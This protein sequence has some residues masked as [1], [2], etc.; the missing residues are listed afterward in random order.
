[1]IPNSTTSAIIG[2]VV[3]LTDQLAHLCAALQAQHE[4]CP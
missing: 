3:S 4:R 2:K 1:M